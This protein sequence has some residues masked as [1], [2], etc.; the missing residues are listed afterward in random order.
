M[1]PDRIIK[2]LRRHSLLVVMHAVLGTII[3]LAVGFLSPPVYV[4][5]ASALIVTGE[6]DATQG[7]SS[8]SAVIATVMPT[9]IELG[10][11][12]SVLTE[13]SEATGAKP[14]ALKGALSL[15]TP[16]N[17]FLLKISASAD[18]PEKAQKIAQAE[19]DA[20]SRVVGRMS[21]TGRDQDGNLGLILSPYDAPSLPGAPTG[22]STISIALAGLVIG[23]LVG[24]AFA[25]II[26]L[27]RHGSPAAAQPPVAAEAS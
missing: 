10:T 17:T 22:P 11:S 9:I 12:Q 24:A 13:V 25:I 20:L 3:G 5:T 26:E 7:V 6:S 15:S 19:L 1:E 16:T 2:A 27:L 23:A 8:S 4:S 21:L 18:T 14:E